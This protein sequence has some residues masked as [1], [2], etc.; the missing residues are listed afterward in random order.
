M[1][2]DVD[3]TGLSGRDAMLEGI[4]YEGDENERG[5][6]RATIGT[7]IYL[8][9]YGYVCGEADAHQF[10]VVADEIHLFAKG[11]K[12]LLI[13]VEDVAQQAA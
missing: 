3:K 11:D 7:N 13:V 2:M 10:N 4:L 8:R 6:F 1:E 5:Y 9:L 12:I